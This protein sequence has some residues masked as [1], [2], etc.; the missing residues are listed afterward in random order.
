MIRAQV[1]FEKK[2]KNIK[3]KKSICSMDSY[4]GFIK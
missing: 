4:D 3:K 1:D 2:K